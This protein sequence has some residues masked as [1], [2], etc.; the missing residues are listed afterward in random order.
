MIARGRITNRSATACS[1]ESVP[2]LEFLSD[3]YAQ[4]RHLAAGSIEQ[5]RIAIRVFDRFLGRPSTLADLNRAS[6]T[7]FVHW[8]MAQGAGP[9]TVASKRASL[10]ALW[11]FAF[12]EQMLDELPHR[13][14]AVRIPEK[15]PQGWTEEELRRILA[16]INAMKPGKCDRYRT[17]PGGV[18]RS[19]FFR[20]FA[21]AYL[22]TG[23][24]F[25]AGLSIKR[26]DVRPD[27]TFTVRYYEQKTWVEQPKQYSLEAWAAI[28]A[29]GEHEYCFPYGRTKAQARR[30]RFWWK[31]ILRSAGLDDS[32]GTGAQQL[33]RT[34][35]SHKELQ[36]PG[37]ATNF[38][39]HKTP[40][41]AKKSYIA[42]RIVAPSLVAGPTFHFA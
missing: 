5:K 37:T 36:Q 42:P 28:Q 40:G 4:N 34:A 39:G 14:M 33:R 15:E 22:S 19:K 41:L 26:R 3:C 24:R 18:D 12:D 25:S 11:R 10:L 7:S 9:N 21:L 6:V 2:L 23:L 29:L 38:L 32:R 30:L 27:R 16:A 17:L 20:A 35:A 13:I 8:Y 31:R 1:H